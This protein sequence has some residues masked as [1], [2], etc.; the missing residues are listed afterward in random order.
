MNADGNDSKQVTD[1]EGG[2]N[3][4]N[5]PGNYVVDNICNVIDN[6]SN[7]PINIKRDTRSFD[8][9]LFLYLEELTLLLLLLLLLLISDTV[10]SNYS[11]VCCTGSCC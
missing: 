8:T 5:C 7:I 1:I 6:E 2:I 11:S 3:T 10:S 4:N 9:A